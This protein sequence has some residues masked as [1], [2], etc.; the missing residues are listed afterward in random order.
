MDLL[1]PFERLLDAHAPDALGS[2]LD[3]A[4]YLDLLVPGTG[5]GLEEA[6]PV[7]R[8]LGRRAIDLPVA[9]AMAARATAA[10]PSDSALADQALL[11]VLA[12][13]EIAGGGEALLD[14]CLAHANTRRQFGRA[15]GQ[16]QAVQHQLAQL[17]EQ[18]VLVRVAA[19]AACRAGPLPP[20]PLAAMAK[21]VASAAVPVMT[22]I[23]H[24][25]HGAIGITRDFPLHR[26]TG[27]L[28][29]LRMT[30]GSESFWAERL[31]TARLAAAG[32]GEPGA[33]LGFVRA[34]LGG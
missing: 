15:I 2:A 23:A 30:A 1:G 20:V 17:A 31:G 25:V 19:E 10:A 28:H 3:A 16:F 21:T 14:M 9:E 7:L 4:G 34:V 18:V 33:S 8:A 12:A 27:Q 6:P 29:R 22:G 11:A 5:P 13:N 32:A 26:I 24:A